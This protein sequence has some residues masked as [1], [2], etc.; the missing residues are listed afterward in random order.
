MGDDVMADVPAES[1]AAPEESVATAAEDT[2]EDEGAITDK[3]E[4]KEDDEDAEDDGG[5]IGL[6]PDE[7]NRGADKRPREEAKDGS[8]DISMR[9]CKRA[10]E[11]GGKVDGASEDVAADEDVAIATEDQTD[12]VI[13]AADPS[14]GRVADKRPRENAEDCSDDVDMSS[15]GEVNPRPLKIAKAGDGVAA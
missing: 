9:P 6:A 12:E 13:I 1:D 8:V 3:E 10:K 4:R 5:S 7:T 11:N 2:S 14:G 15:S